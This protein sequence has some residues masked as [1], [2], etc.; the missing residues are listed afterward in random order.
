VHDGLWH[1]THNEPGHERV[2][3]EI[4]AWLEA[5]RPIMGTGVAGV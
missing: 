2:V 3:A 5:Q 1:E 4:A